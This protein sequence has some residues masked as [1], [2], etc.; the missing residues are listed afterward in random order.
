MAAYITTAERTI[1]ERS[2]SARINDESFTPEYYF[3][4]REQS[5]ESV[6]DFLENLIEESKK[7]E[8]TL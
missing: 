2:M 5:E 7:E 3:K 4:L 1:G 6:V 8:K